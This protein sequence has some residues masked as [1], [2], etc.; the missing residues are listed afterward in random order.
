M[1]SNQ[2]LEPQSL[3]NEENVQPECENDGDSSPFSVERVITPRRVISVLSSASIISPVSDIT[4][5][6]TE[7]R[8]Q[9]C[10]KVLGNLKRNILDFDHDPSMNDYLELMEAVKEK[11]NST[12]DRRKKLS[13]LTLAPNSWTNRKTSEYFGVLE[14]DMA[15]ARSNKEK[16][17]I[18]SDPP[19]EKNRKG[20]L[21]DADKQRITE[22]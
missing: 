9:N 11:I 16:Y 14:Y 19:S 4:R 3:R 21:T 12:E 7:R 22:F 8:S 15:K 18:L 17:G 5:S 10:A 20:Q 6:N 1:T 13:L 2:N